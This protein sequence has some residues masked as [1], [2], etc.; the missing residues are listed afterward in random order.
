M[1]ILFLIYYIFVVFL[2]LYQYPGQKAVLVCT[3]FLLTVWIG[4]RSFGYR[5]TIVYVQAFKDAP[6][7][8]E[9][10]SY[11]WNQFDE[12]YIEKGFFVLASF[13][14]SISSE[15]RFYLLSIGGI[16]MFLLYKS[17]DKYCVVPLLGICDYIG[18]FLL[19]RDFIQMRSSIAILMIVLSVD[20]IQQRK[21]L[22][23]FLVVLVA[24]QFHHVALIAVPFY[25]L[26]LLKIKRSTIY[27]GLVF[28]LIFSQTG[29]SYISGWVDNYSED[30]SYSTYTQGQFVDEALGLRNPII[31]FQLLILLAFTKK[32][33]VLKITTPYYYIFR[34]G[35]FY[36]T[37]ILIIFCNY[38]ALSGRTSTMF[39]TYECFM[40]PLLAKV[41][42]KKLRVCYYF[43]LGI[44]LL[45]FF[46][47]KY[48]QCQIDI[49]NFG[50]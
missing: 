21:A 43:G 30:L 15:P 25:F 36:S 9:I 19:N 49:A 18:R 34:N 29:S 27:I 16:S 40:L 3:C 20:L 28:A 11:H 46:Y 1:V 39:A 37:L 26:N 31:Y 33:D 24:Y 42:D 14:K 45:L 5:D 48:A 50:G 41:F 4:M 8:W 35:Y 32:E 47:S 10:F 17:L 2:I 44:V 38:T 13:F 23:F 22:K 7:I 12:G 6:P